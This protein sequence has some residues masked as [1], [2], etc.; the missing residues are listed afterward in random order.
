MS[1]ARGGRERILRVFAACGRE[2]I[3]ARATTKAINGDKEVGVT[4]IH[5]SS[6]NVHDFDT[7]TAGELGISPAELG[8]LHRLQ[9][10]RATLQLALLVAIFV[11]AGVVGGVVDRLPVLIL[12]WIVQGVALTGMLGA[13]HFCIHATC[14]G[15]PYDRTMGTVLCTPLLT[16]FSVFKN[17]HLE[18][19]RT[20]GT[21]A[22]PQPPRVFNSVLSYLIQLSE[23][24]FIAKFGRW[25][26]W[27]L[28]RKYPHFV[29]TAS[30]KKAVRTDTVVLLAWIAAVLAAT[31]VWPGWM[32]RNYWAP[33]LFFLPVVF[34]VTLGE[35]YGCEKGED[36]YR[37]T[38]SIKSA[39]PLA[40]VLWHLN[41][42]GEHHVFP[43]M[44]GWNLSKLPPALGKRFIHC[45]PSYFAFHAWVLS[46]LARRRTAGGVGS[47]A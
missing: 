7:S 6:E 42:H 21:D 32:L 41:L 26:L 45:Q 35:H 11:G 8:D 30:G 46:R 10:V 12:Q 13:A 44:P 24:R 43:R 18:H 36:I 37:N 23:L 3:L 28:R 29:R 9:P 5:A 25:S 16:N 15:K 40:I 1:R 22:D 31:A 4:S 2:F 27:S 17:F 14:W 34:I 38:R 20:T 47:G 39:W 19:H 33:W